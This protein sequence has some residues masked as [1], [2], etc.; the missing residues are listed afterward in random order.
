MKS[1]GISRLILILLTV[2]IA[3]AADW[4]QYGGEGGQQYT[5][6]TQISRS[7]LDKL[8][9]AWTHR[10]GDLNQDF[11]YKAHSFQT[12]PVQWGE[13]LYFS[14]SSNQVFAVNGETGHELWRFDP[15]L[16]KD[17]EYSESASRGVSLWH[18]EVAGET[19]VCPHRVFLGTLTGLVYALDAET[20][21][22]CDD[23]GHNGHIDMM[24]GVGGAGDWRGQYG[25]TSPPAVAGDQ[26]IIGSAVGDNQMVE[27]PRGIV[28]AV[29]VRTGAINWSW[30]PILRGIEG[31]NLSGAA[32]VWAPISVDMAR[33]LVFL[34]TTSP[35][36]D[37]YG[38][39]RP[40][41]NSYANSLVAL[42][43][44]TGEIVW[45]RQLVHH[46]VWD[47]D[48]A[49]QPT[50]TEIRRN[51]ADVPAVVVVTKTGMLYAFNRDTGES[52]YEIIEKPVPHSDVFG[53]QLSDTQPFS[54]IP[55]LASQRRLT[56]DDAFGLTWFDRRG[57]RKTLRE[58]RSEGI[59]TP[60]SLRGTIEYPSYAGGANWGGVAIDPE[61]QIAITNVN[62]IATLVRL[63]PRAELKNLRAA[64]ELEDWDVSDQEGTPYYMARKVFVSA[65][66]MPCIQPPWGKLVAVDLKKGSILW[67]VPLGTTA[68]L[69]PALVPDLNWGV[70]NLGGAL[71][72]GSGLLV[73]GAVTEHVLRIFDTETGQE[74]W[75]HRLPTAAMA[76]PMSYEIKGVQYIAVA[77]GGHEMLDMPAG[78][79]LMAFRLE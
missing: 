55:P 22:P 31:D 73:I 42:N 38:G 19:L 27:S 10:N 28:R 11:L 26:L 35:S 6:L 70:P 72:T 39:Q 32:N 67:D 36:P 52:L 8:V 18:E 53:E 3:H 51:G 14:S 9:P 24:D 13:K 43:L 50:L 47:Y 34:S 48:I 37:F 16:P 56:E 44:E 63:I 46:D 66:G 68:D 71:L 41:D 60:P 57:C 30:D 1:F 78:D 76:T 74:L 69:A 20:G 15:K 5:P 7:N 49:A 33:G 61:R 4:N 79:Y 64:G 2:Q 21:K 54:A 45:H 40:G 65:L 77:V 17:I 75:S 58:F 23:F 62:Q 59:F 25:I 29:N 12:H